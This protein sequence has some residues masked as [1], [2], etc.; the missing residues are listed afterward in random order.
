MLPFAES[1]PQLKL[2]RSRDTWRELLIE[3]RDKVGRPAF[4]SFHEASGGI[5]VRGN[6][7]NGSNGSGSGSGALETRRCDR[8]ACQK[9][10]CFGLQ[11]A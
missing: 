10:F 9:H 6:Q 3:G 1:L 5:Y 4:K 11:S 8:H 7:N 2:R